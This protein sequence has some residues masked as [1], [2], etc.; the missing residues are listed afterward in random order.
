MKLNLE[1]SWQLLMSDFM[2]TDN[3]K[4][5]MT[6]VEREY[7]AQVVYPPM[8][9]VY[10]AFNSTP[11]DKVKVVILGQDPYH[12]FGQAHG[13][14]FSVPEG[15]KHPPSL[16][17]IIKELNNDIGVEISKNGNLSSWAEQGVLMFNATLTVREKM[18]GSHQK[19]GWEEFTD[20]LIRRI[21]DK[22]NNCVFILWGNFAQKKAKLIDERKNL[23]IKGI[24]P[25]PLSAHRGFFGSKPFSQTNEYLISNNIEPID[26]SIPV[27]KEGNK[28]QKSLF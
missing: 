4:Q 10:Y 11:V 25:S 20:E 12:G 17:N 24:H 9:E 26:W 27:L 22:C 5:L 14:C 2:K 18:A 8:D 13:L 15:Q 6:F 19:Q 16:K 28:N 21:S 3:Y 23:I 7:K 1:D